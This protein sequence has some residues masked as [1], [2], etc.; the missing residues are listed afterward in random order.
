MFARLPP[1]SSRICCVTA[2]YATPLSGG[3]PPSA[4]ATCL[5]YGRQACLCYLPVLR[6]TGGR[7]AT[8]P[9]HVG[10]EDARWLNSYEFLN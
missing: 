5:C 10:I 4:C 2:S 6:Q 9:N 8:P 3:P 1:R 7:Q